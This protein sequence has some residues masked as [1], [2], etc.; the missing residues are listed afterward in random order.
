MGDVVEEDDGDLMGDG[1][2]IAT[3]LER[4]AE[5]GTVLLSEDAYRQVKSRLDLTVHDLG[6][7]QLKNIAER[8]RVYSL[9]VSGAPADIPRQVGS[10]RVWLATG[11]V[12]IVASA[13]GSFVLFFW[14]H[15]PQ[16]ALSRADLPLSCASLREYSD[17]Y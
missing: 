17:R 7:V 9:R 3:R 8:V 16:P 6:E 15:T 1:V 11:T 14:N 10:K 12:G 13:V 4:N 5:P 2:N